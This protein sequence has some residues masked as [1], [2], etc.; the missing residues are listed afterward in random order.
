M[1]ADAILDAARA[2]FDNM[3]GQVIEVPEWGMTGD[4]AARYDPPSLRR[5]QAIQ[6]QAQKSEARM[7]ALTVIHCL[8]DAEGAP[9]FKNDAPTLA[10]LE[11]KVDPA[12]VAR[13]ATKILGVSGEADLGN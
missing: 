4:A 9:I 6:S 1:N 10:T 7:M 11:T 5:R 3:R 12:V 13:V 2:H 8:K